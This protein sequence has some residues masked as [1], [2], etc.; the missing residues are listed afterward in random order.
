MAEITALNWKPAGVAVNTAAFA[1]R[2]VFAAIGV[3]VAVG[4]IKLQ[5]RPHE[6][7]RGINRKI[8]GLSSVALDAP[9]RGT[10]GLMPPEWGVVQDF[11]LDDTSAEWRLQYADGRTLARGQSSEGTLN[12]SMT[13]RMPSSAVLPERGQTFLHEWRGVPRQFVV[14]S[15][16]PVYRVRSIRLVDVTAIHELDLGDR[17]PRATP[18]HEWTLTLT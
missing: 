11:D 6:E 7:D 5:I 3:A 4:L 1:P 10:H 12:I 13:L 8:T 17:T 2:P 15:V 16:S 9:P 14:W 18:R